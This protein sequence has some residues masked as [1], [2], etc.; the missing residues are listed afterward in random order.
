[1]NG[2]LAGGVIEETVGEAINIGSGTEQRVVDMARIVNK[3]TGNK[4][5][6]QHVE[7]REWDAKPQ[8]LSSIDKARR[9][10]G[11]QPQVTFKDGL[12]KVH[13][14][15]VENWENIEESAEF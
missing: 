9:L 1:M 15:F 7:R 14:W 11:Y 13:E 12:R 4:S 6:I 5:G 2:L 8:L 10:I 3:L